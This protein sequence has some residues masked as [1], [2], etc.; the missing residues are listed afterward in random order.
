[1]PRVEPS[2]DPTARLLR[3]W[4]GLNNYLRS[5]TEDRVLL[6]LLRRA[7]E[8]GAR[9]Q[10]IERLYQRYST[11]RH[12]REHAALLDATNKR[13]EGRQWEFPIA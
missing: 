5:A 13:K 8:L 3:S 9:T 12:Q 11:L 4:E 7:I 6:P 10:V 2:T 1:V